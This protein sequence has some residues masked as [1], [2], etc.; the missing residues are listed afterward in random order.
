MY[1]GGC[2]SPAVVIGFET[3]TQ[4]SE[5]HVSSLISSL[6][7]CLGQ[8]GKG[9][10]FSGWQA[11]IC[12]LL[13]QRDVKLQQ[14]I[15]F[16]SLSPAQQCAKRRP[17]TSVHSCALLE[18]ISGRHCLALIINKK[19]W[20]K[21]IIRS[22]SGEGSNIDQNHL[23]TVISR[24]YIC[25]LCWPS[26]HEKL[27]NDEIKFGSKIAQTIRLTYGTGPNQTWEIGR[28][29]MKTRRYVGKCSWIPTN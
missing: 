11:S 28:F 5:V 9:F 4:S 29:S 19:V 17:K 23:Y 13:W 12:P 20:P 26:F 6:W 10:N 21:S 15:N 3:T 25:L 7:Q 14:T 18:V 1:R 8:G 2:G 24:K 27:T 16:I 22:L